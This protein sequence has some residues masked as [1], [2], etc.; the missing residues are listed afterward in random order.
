MTHGSNLWILIIQHH[1]YYPN[2]PRSHKSFSKIPHGHEGRISTSAWGLALP[3]LTL[4]KH[5]SLH[6]Q[7]HLQQGSKASSHNPKGY[8][9][10]T[11]QFLILRCQPWLYQPL[12]SLDNLLIPNSHSESS[13]YNPSKVPL[14]STDISAS[15][16]RLSALLGNALS[17]M[18]QWTPRALR[19]HYWHKTCTVL[20]P[21][22]L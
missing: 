15:Q 21:N 18:L 19:L 1:R 6:T 7:L 8:A 5:F 4:H 2:E 14:N 13:S 16:S 9:G 22:M 12:P 11:K 20:F 10:K 3:Q 17:E